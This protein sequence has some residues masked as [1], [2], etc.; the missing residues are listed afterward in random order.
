VDS[1]LTP[2][3]ALVAPWR[4]ATI[5][6]AGIAVLELTLVIALAVTLLTRED[7][8]SAATGTPAAERPALKVRPI[9]PR[10]RTHVLV[11]NGNGEEGAAAAQADVVRSLGYGV[12]A[13]GNATHPNN[14]SSTV[15]YVAG[16]EREA[17][18]LA[19][20]LGISVV[21]PLDGLS[22][23]TLQGAHV[24]VILGR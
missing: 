18:R 1:T 3:E 10:T 12:S 2:A 7:S 17:S 13:V 19:K 11:L 5:V 6:A 8:P 22:R 9:L 14:G 24:A 16:R 20:E 15:L 23:K 21:G 4:R